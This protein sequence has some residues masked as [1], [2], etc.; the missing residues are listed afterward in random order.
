M[1]ETLERP[2]SCSAWNRFTFGPPECC[3][4]HW[5]HHFK[6]KD[7]D[8]VNNNYVSHLLDIIAELEEKLRRK[9][10]ADNG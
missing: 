6:L 9:N 10:N 4:N 5:N 7:D 1:K 3:T 2:N 8:S